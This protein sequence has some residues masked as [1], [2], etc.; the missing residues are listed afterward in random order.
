MKLKKY[1]IESIK[2]YGGGS[3]TTEIMALNIQHALATFVRNKAIGVESAIL[4][5]YK[6]NKVGDAL[7]KM[8]AEI[9]NPIMILR[10]YCGRKKCYFL[11]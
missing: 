1:V 9:D 10:V 3:E 2:L 4:L 8:L 5:T 7:N 11:L 6:P